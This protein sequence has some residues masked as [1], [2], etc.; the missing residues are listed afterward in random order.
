MRLADLHWTVRRDRIKVALTVV[1]QD[2]EAPATTKEVAQYIAR[3]LEASWD[4]LGI[5]CNMLTRH[6]AKETPEAKQTTAG[7]RRYGRD[8]RPWI[9]SPRRVKQESEL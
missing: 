5:I 1:L 2:L 9:W 8:M 4:D 6:L 7:F 3:R